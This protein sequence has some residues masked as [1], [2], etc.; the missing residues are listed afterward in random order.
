MSVSSVGHV[1]ER[2]TDLEEE[3]QEKEEE[4]EEQVVGSGGGT[5][6]I[7]INTSPPQF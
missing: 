3:E 7:H 1:D 5:L 4:E 6:P 2:N